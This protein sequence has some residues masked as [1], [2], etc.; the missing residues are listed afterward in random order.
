MSLDGVKLTLPSRYPDALVWDP[1]TLRDA[2]TWMTAAGVA[3]LLASCISIPDW[4]VA[5]AVGMDPS[6][7]DLPERRMG[8]IVGTLRASAAALKEGELAAVGRMA[9]LLALSG[10]GM[11]FS[12]ASPRLQVSST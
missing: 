7:T 1:V 10:F 12:R 11:S 3:D 2:P 9:G 6:F 5:H 8:D 4:P